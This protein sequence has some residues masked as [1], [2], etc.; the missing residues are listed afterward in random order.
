M[1]HSLGGLPEHEIRAIL[2]GNALRIFD[3]DL[4]K[5]RAAADR[6]G[7]TV[8]ELSTPLP[9]ADVPPHATAWAFAPYR[10]RTLEGA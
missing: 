5:L 3:F 1:R 4:A 7:P 2:A 6:V 9:A 10:M 8:E